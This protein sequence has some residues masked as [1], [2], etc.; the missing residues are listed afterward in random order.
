LSALKTLDE[1]VRKSW[2]EP[3]DFYGWNYYRGMRWVAAISLSLFFGSLALQSKELFSREGV[4]PSAELFSWVF[5]PSLFAHF[6]TA[7][8]IYFSLLTCSLFALILGTGYFQKGMTLILWYFLASS[9]NRNPF[10]QTFTF[11][12]LGICL[13][14]LFLMPSDRS[15]KMPKLLYY[16]VNSLLF[17]SYS[18][19]GISKL[20]T[21][22]WLEGTAVEITLS[23]G[24]GIDHALN[25]FLL[26]HSVVL[27][28]LTYY[29]LLVEILAFPLFLKGG[30]WRLMAW[31]GIVVMHLGITATTY[32]SKMSLAIILT[33]LLFAPKEII[34]LF[35]GAL[36]KK[37]PVG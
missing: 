10:V 8:F 11:D 15:W 23:L 24:R 33:H 6:D 7:G 22:P 26:D 13:G 20:R 12:Y 3:V 30:R 16:G 32:I 34:N 5:F 17:L 9:A 27:K 35:E 18:F 2:E 19:S 1:S 14:V 36:R 31:L 29:S 25:R 21:E 28:P 37:N 4:F